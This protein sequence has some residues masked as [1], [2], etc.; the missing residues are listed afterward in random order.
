MTATQVPIIGWEQRYMSLRECK[1]LQSMESLQYLPSSNT[2]AFES[3]G[4][5]VNVDVARRVAESLLHGAAP[6]A[7][8]ESRQLQLLQLE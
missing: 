4:N 8:R 1:R 2:K 5:A 6:A 7:Q 3:L